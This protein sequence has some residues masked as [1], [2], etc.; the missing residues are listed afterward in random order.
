MTSS[1]DSDV[2]RGS[3]PTPVERPGRKRKRKVVDISNDGP[4]AMIACVGLANHPWKQGCKTF[5]AEVS[6]ARQ[7]SGP[8]AGRREGKGW[9]TQAKLLIFQ[10]MP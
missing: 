4:L 10:S 3:L 7:E 2:V 6:A 1:S 5:E 9:Q 8:S